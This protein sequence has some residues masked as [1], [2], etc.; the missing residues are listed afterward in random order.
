MSEI[1]EI[2]LNK[3]EVKL[4]DSD[5]PVALKVSWEPANP[6]G[7]NFKTQKMTQRDN[8]IVIEKTKIA[9]VLALVFAVP[10]FLALFIGSPW[11]FIAG[12]TFAGVFMIVWGVMFGGAGVLLLKS[13][14]KFTID[15]I[16]GAYYRGKKFD[17]LNNSDRDQQGYIRDIHAIQLIDERIR[18]SSS[19]GGSSTYTSYE[20]NLVFKDAERINIMDHGKREDVENSA[21][22]LG[23]F[24]NIPIW[25]AHY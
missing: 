17:S 2:K 5:D 9:Y 7:A 1:Q 8:K 23:Q 13:D 18:S 10:G 21:K 4:T 22:E 15:R 12:D 11:L 3:V 14:K 25:K 6:G 24:L 16:K 20:M 19:S